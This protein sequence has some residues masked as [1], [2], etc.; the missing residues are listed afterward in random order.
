MRLPRGRLI[1]WAA[2]W[3]VP[4][5][6]LAALAPELAGALYALAVLAMAA[7]AYDALRAGESLRGVEAELPA[8]TRMTKA[9]DGQLTVRLANADRRARRIRFGIPMPGELGCAQEDISVDLPAGAEHSTV[10]LD[11]LPRRRGSYRLEEVYLGAVSPWGFWLARRRQRRGAEVRVYPNLKGERKRMAAMFLN[12]GAFGLHAQRQIGQGRE[13]EQLR[14]YIRGDAYQD[15]HWKATAKRGRPATKMYQIE[16]TQEV[17]VLIDASRLS[18]R[19]P[20]AEVDA[21]ERLLVPPNMLERFITAA[22][23]FGAVA[24]RQGD[25]FGVGSFSDRVD[26]FV[27]ARN[28]Q[29]HYRACRDALYSLHARPVSP[30][31]A[32][33]FSFLHLRL[34]RR[35]LLVFLTNLDDPILSETFSEH[36]GLLAR[37]HVV[38][39]NQLSPPGVGPLFSGRDVANVDDVYER[40]GGHLQW[41]RLRET[42]RRLSHR[43]VQFHLPTNETL[44]PEI[45]TQYL[46]VKRRQLL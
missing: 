12:R 43:G 40:L 6:L 16:R 25:L 35:A 46:N 5:A 29:T 9:A 14:P 22:L 21:D 37:R 34:R 42:H 15:I 33:L 17:Y 2:A 1:V 8:L 20:T 45:V 18:A 36:V 11:C 44:C 26:R 30:D 28:G 7:P 13:F 3:F 23:V 4:A 39:V 41:R 31:F 38:L 19:Q 24:E 27:R 32:E 10:T